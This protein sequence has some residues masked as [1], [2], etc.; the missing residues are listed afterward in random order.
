M[1][2]LITSHDGHYTEYVTKLATFGSS[3]GDC[4]GLGY[5]QF[6]TGCLLIVASMRMPSVVP[7]PTFVTVD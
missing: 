4:N 6:V 7:M 2:A 3:I 5:G 1:V